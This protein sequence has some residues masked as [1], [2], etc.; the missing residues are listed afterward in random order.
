MPISSDPNPL[1]GDLEHILSRTRDLWEALRGQSVF[2]TGGTG[3]FGRWLLE[4]F[5]YANSA[6]DLN[7]TLVA[8]SRDPAAFRRKAPNFDRHSCVKFVAGDVRS[9]T[10]DDVRTQLGNDAPSNF[11]YVIHAATEANA[12][13]HA[14][15]DLLM[16]DTIVQGTR[17]ALDFAVATGATRF[18]LTSS[19]AVYGRQPGDLTHIPEDYR[20]A[21]DCTDPNSAYGEGKRLAELLC[22]CYAKRHGIQPLIAR[23]FAFVGPFLPLDTHFAIGNF[24]RD[25]L[26]GNPIQINGDGTPY[27]SYLYAADLAIW[28]WTILCKG[29]PMRPY[30]VGSDRDLTIAELAHVVQAALGRS[31]PVHI[32]RTP[33]P[34]QLPTRYV[35]DVGRAE[36]ELNLSAAIDLA[37]AVRRTA[38]AYDPTASGAP[39]SC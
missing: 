31:A 10:A 8:L 1:A 29:A 23:C 15:S 35:P 4:S 37:T 19:G 14:D 21:P 3:F 5:V 25:A 32:A 9:F 20:G 39:P 38:A 12:K 28:L 30:N 22:A 34:N 11:Q 24:I 7:A 33:S 27:R 17:S 6:L 13:P 26:A 16:V 2:V 36:D 18:L